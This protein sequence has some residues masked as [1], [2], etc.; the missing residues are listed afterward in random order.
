MID[1]IQ[2]K[3]PNWFGIMGKCLVMGMF[4]MVIFILSNLYDLVVLIT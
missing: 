4:I 3:K 1:N 2:F